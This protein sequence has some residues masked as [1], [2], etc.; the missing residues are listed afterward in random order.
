MKDEKGTLLLS[1]GIDSPVAGHLM[2]SQGTEV[3][4]LHCSLEPFTDR[5][6]EEKSRK[7][8]ETLG[9]SALY[10]AHL[11]DALA[12]IARK[13][14]RRYY[15]VLSKRLMFRVAEELAR[16]EGSTF[17]I[18]GESLGQVSSQTLWNL[19]AIEAAV[20]L[21]VLRPLIG[22]DKIDIIREAER[23]GT[24]PISVGPEVCDVLGPAHPTTRAKLEVVEAEEARLH[25]DALLEGSVAALEEAALASA[26]AAEAK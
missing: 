18:T 14:R 6:P 7:I 11:G 12:Q 25:Y 16:R 5:A 9:F 20:N 4:A 2:A 24:F 10:V 19:R 3:L 1:G 23:I 26:P 17:L 21:P 22:W 8:A 15:F 13:A